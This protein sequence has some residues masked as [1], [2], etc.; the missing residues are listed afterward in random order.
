MI[1]MK[2]FIW[3][4][5]TTRNPANA[6]LKTLASSR[7]KTI[8][9]PPRTIITP[10]TVRMRTS[11][12]TTS[13]WRRITQSSTRTHNRSRL[14][15]IK[16][17]S[18]GRS[19]RI[20]SPRAS[21]TARPAALSTW[22]TRCRKVITSITHWRSRRGETLSHWLTNFSTWLIKPASR[23]LSLRANLRTQWRVL[24]GCARASKALVLAASPPCKN[25]QQRLCLHL[26]K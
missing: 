23:K 6:P 18:S 11:D 13:K 26:Q 16:A 10:S 21:T 24:K 22:A 9:Q 5:A 17:S 19:K 15:P 3:R 20:G 12:L 14:L 2:T 4:R 25:R 1:C 7:I 8:R